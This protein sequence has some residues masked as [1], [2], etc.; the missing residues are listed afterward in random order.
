MGAF[1]LV[2]E[3]KESAL[4]YAGPEVTCLDEPFTATSTGNLGNVGSLDSSDGGAASAILCLPGG[5]GSSEEDEAEP[6]A[7]QT[8]S[9]DAQRSVE[10]PRLTTVSPLITSCCGGPSA[11]LPGKSWLA[12]AKQ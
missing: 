4:I 12:A 6:G 11:A 8:P 9:A 3:M 5:V 1:L 2:V 7:P 10:K